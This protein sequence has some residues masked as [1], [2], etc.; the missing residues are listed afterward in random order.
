ME[1][2]WFLLGLVSGGALA[3][4]SLLFLV[5]RARRPPRDEPEDPDPADW[6]KSR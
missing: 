1:L 5:L 4:V 6:W 2:V 3:Y